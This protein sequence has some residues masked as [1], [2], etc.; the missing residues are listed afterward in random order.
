MNCNKCN[1]EI[2]SGAKF[3]PECGALFAE[4]ADANSAVVSLDKP[5]P[6]DSLVSAM[7]AAS[8]ADFKTADPVP[9]PVNSVPTPSNGVPMLSNGN[10]TGFSS[11]FSGMGTGTSA[12][13]ASGFEVPFNG[14]AAAVIPTKKKN[15]GKIAII[16]AAV[17]AVIV[18]SIA[19]IFFTNRAAFLSTLLGKTKYATMVEGNSI[20]EFTDKIDA[21]AISGGIKS[22]SEFYA[23]MASANTVYLSDNSSGAELAP[24][25]AA[26]TNSGAPEM[27]V[28]AMIDALN[29]SLAD[30]YG[31]SS[32][33][34]KLSA[35]VELTDST[36]A[37]IGGG[38]DLDEILKLVNGTSF[39]YKVSASDKAAAVSMG[40][41]GEKFTINAKSVMTDD[42]CVYIALPF[43]SDKAIMF[44]CETPAAAETVEFKALELDEKEIER[45]LGEVVNIYLENYKASAIEMESGYISAGDATAEGKM[46]TA[47]FKGKALEKL[48]SDIAEH[49]ADDDYFCDKIVE[50]VN[51]CGGDL[52]KSEYREGITDAFEFNASNKDK[53]IIKTV[54]DRNGNVLAKSY[55]AKSE[56]GQEAYFAYIDTKDQSAIE[57]FYDD[58]YD[59]VVIEITDNKENDTDGTVTV[60]ISDDEESLS[61]KVDYTGVKMDK[62]CGQDVCV[63]KYTV[64]M[65]LPEDF[66]DQLGKDAFAAVNGAKL[67]FD[68]SLNGSKD[69]VTSSVGLE[70]P[71]YG[72]VTV[73]CDVTASDDTSDIKVPTNVIDVTPLFKDDYNDALMDELE[74]FSDDIMSAIEKL[75]IDMP[76]LGA[77]GT[78]GITPYPDYPYNDP[79]DYDWNYDY[80]WADDYDWED[81]D[82]GDFDWDDFDWDF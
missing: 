19:A 40:A 45:L 18:G 2:P 71:K 1:S 68:T 66:S 35:K 14:A 69:S 36:K 42:G 74:K 75:D 50:Y 48:F 43:A 80:D 17:A 32:V 3:C 26:S 54:I 27:D 10:S 78:V 72:S 59:K 49:I 82:W 70:V 46:I 56:D 24:M 5:S 58:G 8:Q 12:A 57:I 77:S 29:R 52:T 30:T 11:G 81:Y 38:D 79:D 21:P 37:L 23:A 60:V 7:N 73:I 6:S 28:K 22:A 65:K 67:V 41:E 20:K 64:S 4:N 13:P 51:D 16:I 55:T 53:L 33:D 34:M 39:T 9:S 25:M 76:S 47:E 62:F 63:G 44:K 61:F 31:V 15:G